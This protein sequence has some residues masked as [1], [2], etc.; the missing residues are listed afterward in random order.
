MIVEKEATMKKNLVAI[1]SLLVVLAL[2]F[3]ATEGICQKTA[4]LAQKQVVVL[5]PQLKAIMPKNATEL[6][7]R[8]NKAQTLGYGVAPANLPPSGKV[9]IVLQENSGY[10]KILD[11]LRRNGVP[12]AELLL[13]QAIIDMLAETFEDLKTRLQATGRY[14]RVILLTDENGTYENLSRNMIEYSR[15]NKIIDMVVL[16]HGLPEKLYLKYQKLWGE[17][18]AAGTVPPSDVR[19]IRKLGADFARARV[20]N[21]LRLVYL[22]N[23]Y[24]QTTNN[25]WT[26]IG[27]KVSIG[28]YQINY[29]PEPMTTFFMNDWISGQFTASQA[30]QRSWNGSIP[31]YSLVYP[32]VATTQFQSATVR[33]PCG[34]SWDITKFPWVWVTKYCSVTVQVP[35]G[36][37]LT[38]HPNILSS[39]PVFLGNGELRF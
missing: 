2:T 5:S 9:L 16:G 32:P 19:M 34:G 38:P 18:L 35:V 37:N 13:L 30:A 21:K 33:Y 39:R 17:S 25:D 7:A 28:P 4:P 26:T 20:T 36:V 24:G 31:W 8:L 15:Q 3:C 1:A 22:C 12:E 11:D 14:E 6:K 27:A 10:L 23:C 29:M